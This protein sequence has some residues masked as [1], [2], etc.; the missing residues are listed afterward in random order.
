MSSTGATA[1][2]RYTAATHVGTALLSDVVVTETLT[3]L[4]SFTPRS[5]NMI[6][7]VRYLKLLQVIR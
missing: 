7:D 2:L 6:L 3:G 4:T 5:N 1:R